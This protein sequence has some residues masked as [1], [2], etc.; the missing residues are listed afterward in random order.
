MENGFSHL[1]KKGNARI[2]NISKKK[3]SSRYAKAQ[4]T[5]WL[6]SKIIS[7]IK[8][9]EFKKGNAKILSTKL[10]ETLS[11]LRE[12]K[13][14][15]IILVPRRGYSGFLSCRNCGYVVNCPNCDATLTVHSGTRGSKWLSCHWCNFKRQ[16]IN[17][18]PE[19]NSKAFKPFGV[20]P[21]EK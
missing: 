20:S 16:F 3:K 4:A 15:A 5:I 21:V 14:Q 1:D 8:N 11:L 19:C 12:K 6:S 17:F 9:D 13:E 18:C 10:L 7:M 2:V